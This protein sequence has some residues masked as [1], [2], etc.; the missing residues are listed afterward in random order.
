MYNPNRQGRNPYN[1]KFAGSVGGASSKEH[2]E[3]VTK[4]RGQS[5]SVGSVRGGSGAAVEAL[6]ERSLRMT[7]SHGGRRTA[8]AE[9]IA[10]NLRTDGRFARVR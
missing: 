1:G 3:P 2:R 6:D 7:M 4:A 5:H 9:R 10:L 8:V